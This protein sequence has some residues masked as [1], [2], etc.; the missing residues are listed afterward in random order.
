MRYRAACLSCCR[1]REGFSWRRGAL[2]GSLSNCLPAD[3]L[4]DERSVGLSGLAHRKARLTVHGRR[5][6]VERVRVEGQ[7]VA[8][9]A[10]A[11][12]ISRPCAHRWL[13]RFDAEGDTGLFDRSSRPHTMPTRTAPEVEAAVVAA[14]VE[15]RRGQDW[16]GPQLGV[17]PR[18][19]NRIL[20]RHD[21]PS[22]A[23][24][25]PLT[26]TVIRASSKTTAVRYERS[27]PG[28]LVHMDVKKIAGVARIRAFTRHG[29]GGF[30]DL[31]EAADAIASYNPHRP[32]P[33]DLAGLK[34]NLRLKDDGRWYWHWDPR[35]M[36][37]QEP[38]EPG[39]D[40]LPS[41]RMVQPARLEDAAHP[42]RVPTLLV[43]GASSDLLSEE[44]AAAMRELVPHAKQVDVAGAGQT[45]SPA[46]ATTASTPPWWTSSN[47]TSAGTDCRAPSVTNVVLRAGWST[48]PTQR[49]GADAV[50][51]RTSLAKSSQ[52]L[53]KGME[54]VGDSNHRSISS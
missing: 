25:D 24:L 41:A 17:A 47:T 9:V 45:W 37:L 46:T 11:M 7:V 10:K 20:H 53:G 18:T 54:P 28:E 33:K 14:R 42:L 31:Q 5:L 19:V 13:N 22:L 30:A 4:A 44:G 40:G 39:L 51:R 21:M 16:L 32:R 35:F 2:A 29:L 27:R 26:G 23:E 52:S 15:H 36:A 34:K 49:H 12:G 3:C 43:R 50:A 1:R 38:D 48:S 6:L 8:H